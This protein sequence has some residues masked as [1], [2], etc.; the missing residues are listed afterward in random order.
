MPPDQVVLAPPHTVLKTSSGKIRRGATRDFFE[1]HGTGKGQGAVWL[2]LVRLVRTG[3]TPELRRARRASANFLYAAYAWSLFWIL[4]PLAWT[5][6]VAAPALSWRYAILRRVAR[7]FARFSGTPLTVEGAEHLEACAHCVLVTN[8]AS[9]LDSPILVAALPCNFSYVAKRELTERFISRLFLQRIRTAFV[10]RFDKQRGVD[11]ARQTA[12][13]VREGRSLVFFPEGT[14]HRMPGLQPFHMGAFVAAAEAGVP[15][16]PVAIRGTR[17]ILRAGSWFPRRGAVTVTIA[18]PIPPE[19]TDWEAAIR[20]RDAART[21][22]LKH[23][24]EPDLA[25]HTGR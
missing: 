8:H 25:S 13:A 3:I 22:I 24:G 1:R 6:V 20:L 23:C 17:S 15:V 10:E 18:A 14:F 12:A 16:I 2:Q 7:L 21:A 11:D 9:Y 19:G 4:A 5:A